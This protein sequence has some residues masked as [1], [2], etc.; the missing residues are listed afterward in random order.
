MG[1]LFFSH[2]TLLVQDDAE[3]AWSEEGADVLC[4]Q[5]GDMLV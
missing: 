4:D 2:T 1:D 3:L 5:C